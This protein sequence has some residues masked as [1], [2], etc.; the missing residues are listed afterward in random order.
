M[1]RAALWTAIHE[2]LSG[3]IAQGHYAPGD[4]LPTEA[5]LAERF[6]VNRH[7]V[8][9]ALGALAEEG[10]VHAKR[11]AGVFVRHIPTPYPIGQRVRFRQNLLA[12]GRVPER[13]ILHLETRAA[14]ARE[15]DALGHPIKV[16]IYEGVSLSDGVPIAVF[17]SVFPAARFPKLLDALRE[18]RSVTAAFAAHGVTD[19]TRASTLITAKGASRTHAAILEVPQGSP[20]LRTTGLNVDAAGAPVEWGRSWFAADRVTLTLEPEDMELPPTV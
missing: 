17:R 2:T 1:G 13:R 20:I 19:Y 7:T 6:G 18:T 9:R 5:Q 16:H 14:N 15:N 3:E 4:R 8:R 11:G 12:A 10:I